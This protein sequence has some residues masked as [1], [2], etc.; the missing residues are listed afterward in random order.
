M[1][2]GETVPGLI[3]HAQSGLFEVETE[4]GILTAQIR[5]RLKEERQ[6]TD[7]V[8]LGDRVRVR[9]LADGRGQIDAVEPRARVLSRQAP[10]GEREQVIVANP[11]QAMLV[12]ACADPPLNRRM[13]DRMLVAA[14][15]EDIPARICLNKIDLDT[16]AVAEAAR[17]VYQ[18]IG[19]PVHLTSAVT[20]QGVDELRQALQNCIS[21]LA[22]PSGVGKSSLLNAVQPGLGL[23]TGEVRAH[24]R[25]GKHT[26]VALKLV[27]LD[28]GGYIADTPGVKAFAL[29]DIE[30]EELDAY[31]PEI[32]LR[33]ADCAFSD[34][35]HLHEPNCAVRAALEAGAID[36]DRYESYRR[37]RL[38]EQE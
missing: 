37:L 20:G 2:E 14:E 18:A 22:G 10:V 4:D 27:P 24:T 16:D 26:T 7:L 25:K 33:V 32:S 1:A 36:A 8:A 35:T 28:G 9:P 19:Y 15:R 6:D 38:G 21:V 23:R 29:W 11:D 30:P 5:G 34:C 3:V 31:F 12:F 13:L 17:Q